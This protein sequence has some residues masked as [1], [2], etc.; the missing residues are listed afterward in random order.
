[1]RGFIFICFIGC[2]VASLKDLGYPNWQCDSNV[3]RKSA[4]VPKNVN[5]VR[6]GDIKVIG[7]LGDSLTA[8]NGAGASKGD[9]V[10]VILQYRGLAFQIGGDKSLDEHV[11]ITNVL[12]K[13]NPNLVGYSK[14]IGSA[15]VWEVSELNQAIPGAETKDLVGQAR[16]LV[17]LMKKHSEINVQEDWKLVNIFIGA[18]DMCAYCG[19]NGTGAY[20]PKVFK[21]N[22]IDAVKVLQDSLP[23][24]IVSLTGMMDMGMLRTIDRKKY[25]CDGLHVFECPCEKKASFTNDDISAACHLE[26]NAEQQIQDQRVFDTEDFTFVIQPFLNNLT[27]PPM[28]P[29][30]EVDLT[31][32][33][34]DCFHFS[35][36]GHANI[37]KHLWN[38]IIQPVGAKQTSVNLSDP[39]IPLRCPDASCP[40]FRTVQNSKD[41]SKYM[42]N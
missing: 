27:T 34:P 42:T 12:R 38:T 25:F 2:A 17:Q 15:N 19:T 10:A 1:M 8:A 3:M 41:C 4:K 11:T 20:D 16:I 32:F 14:G 40:F 7:A 9:A 21:Q 30:G 29:D 6:Y 18:N 28:T 5:S 33:A 36:F 35:Q 31:W 24:T 23:R 22:I 13:F 37:G 39:T 26:M